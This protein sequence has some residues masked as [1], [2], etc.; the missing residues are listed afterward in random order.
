M[1]IKI[2]DMEENWIEICA[3]DYRREIARLVDQIEWCEN[4]A[5]VSRELLAEYRTRL[6][7]A[8]K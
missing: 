6:E 2:K 8:E 4:M 5:S 1:K 7:E 3:D